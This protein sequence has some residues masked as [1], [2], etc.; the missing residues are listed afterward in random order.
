MTTRQTK[1]KELVS[2]RFHKN[3]K[4]KLARLSKTT[5][6]SQTFLAEEAI[7]QYCDL[8]NW[9]VEAIHQGLKAAKDGRFVSH[10]EIKK[11]WE[12]KRENLMD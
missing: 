2:F 10:D 5:G 3:L 1:G 7:E 6:R 8:Q 12:L 11:R 4:R 9:Q